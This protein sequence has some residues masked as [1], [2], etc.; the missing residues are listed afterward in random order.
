[1][2][3]IEVAREFTSHGKRSVVEMYRG[4]VQQ[5]D[6]YYNG[7]LIITLNVL[8]GNA[9]YKGGLSRGGGSWHEVGDKPDSIYPLKKDASRTS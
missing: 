7:S 3:I 1:M 9:D 8:I 6:G 4:P 2:T 5:T